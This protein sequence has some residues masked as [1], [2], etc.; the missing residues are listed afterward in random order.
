APIITL[1]LSKL[2]IQLTTGY[3]KIVVVDSSLLRVGVSA[4]ARAY[5]CS[6]TYGTRRL[7]FLISTYY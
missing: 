5:R 1:R 2:V 7:Y 6:S 3:N 4:P